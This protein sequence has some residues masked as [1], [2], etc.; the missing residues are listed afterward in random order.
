MSKRAKFV[1]VAIIS[2]LS[3]WL[4]TFASVDFRFGLVMAVSAVVYI[5]SVWVLF[6]DLKGIEWFTLMVLPVSFSLGSGIFANFLP[7][8]IPSMFGRTIG[9]ESSLF[10]ASVLKVVYFL[11]YMVGIYGILLVENIFSVASIRTIQ[12]FRAAR[13]ANFV[14]SLVTLLFFYTMALSLKVPF[15]SVMGLSFV[16]SF[17]ISYVNFWSVDLKSTQYEQVIRYAV[18]VSW[19]VALVGAVLSF[20]PVK[21]FMGGL[22]M[23][24]AIYAL[25]GVLE[26]RLSNRV[27]LEGLM[28]YLVSVVIIFIIG[29]LTTSWLG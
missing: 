24:S 21:P 28:E 2:G 7:A 23:T 17:I 14:F 25:M 1:L 19:I 26:Q 16:A 13:S 10:L 4:T 29:F 11:F 9:Y 6:D 5:L 12:L 27:Y 8:A 22:M 15:W 18:G 3:L 20:W